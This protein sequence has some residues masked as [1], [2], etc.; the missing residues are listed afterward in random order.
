[1]IGRCNGENMMSLIIGFL[2]YKDKIDEEFLFLS[3]F[4]DILI[5]IIVAVLISSAKCAG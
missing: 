4:M 2:I 1:M 3:G 5:I